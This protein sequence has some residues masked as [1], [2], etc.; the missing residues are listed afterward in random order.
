[1]TTEKEVRPQ[2][3]AQ[4]KQPEGK[5]EGELT[6]ADLSRVAGGSI[7]PVINGKSDAPLKSRFGVR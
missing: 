2:S 3:D 6:L 7:G 1:M 4:P 5:I